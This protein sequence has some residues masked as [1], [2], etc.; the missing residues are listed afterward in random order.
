M[1][2]TAF[3]GEISGHRAEGGVIMFTTPLRDVPAPPD[4]QGGYVDKDGK[5]T[6]ALFDYLKKL[7]ARAE[8]AQAALRQLEP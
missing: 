6:Q 4:P 7:Q 8:S 1:P 5:P 3:G 2:V